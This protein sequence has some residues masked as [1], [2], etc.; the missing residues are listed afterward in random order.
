MRIFPGVA[1]LFLSVTLAAQ[2]FPE[3]PV[4]D[5]SYF[6]NSEQVLAAGSDG[7]G[8]LV[9]GRRDTSLFAHRVTAGGALLDGTGIKLATPPGTHGGAIVLGIFWAG[10]AYTVVCRT[11]DSDSSSVF[12]TR[13]D[14]DGRLLEDARQVPTGGSS[15]A[16]AT[17]GKRIVIAGPKLA[18]LDMH[19]N[20]I[21]SLVPLPLQGDSNLFQIASNG[22]GFLV[23]WQTRLELFRFAAEYTILD[24]NGHPGMRQTA[25]SSI[26]YQSIASDGHDYL[27]VY[28]MPQN[29]E[30][31]QHMSA[32]GQL[33]EQH[34]LPILYPVGGY[35]ILWS[36]SAYVVAAQ[37]GAVPEVIR[38]D[39][40]GAAIDTKAVSLTNQGVSSRVVLATNGRQV[41]MSWAETTDRVV[42]FAGLLDSDF[43]L[44][45][46]VPIGLTATVQTAP[47]IA[48][49]GT[50]LFAVWVEGTTIYGARLSLTGQRLGDPIKLTTSPINLP[51]RVIWD[52]QAYVVASWMGYN[53]L[54]TTRVAAD[55]TVLQ[56]AQ[57]KVFSD[58][59]GDFDLASDGSETVFVVAAKC[60]DTGG[61]IAARVHR[62]GNPEPKITIAPTGMLAGSPRAA[63]NG[64]ELLVVWR[65]MFGSQ[66]TLLAPPTYRSNVR[67]ARVSPSMTLLDPDP[68]RIAV[69]DDQDN[70][71]PQVA[72]DGR[73]FLVAWT[74]TGVDVRARTVRADGTLGDVIPALGKGTASS[75]VWDG[76]RYAV[77]FSS[78]A[79][80]TFVRRIGDALQIVNDGPDLTYDASLATPGGGA[81]IAAYDRVASEPVYG[82]VPRVFV[83]GVSGAVR[84]RPVRG[85]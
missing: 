25:A 38:L 28:Q 70:T 11:D 52:G 13:I 23:T 48:S 58:C 51:P 82:T 4:S 43:T 19:G 2:T 20:L 35:T 47:S 3:R 80:N 5:V 22:D 24:A 81:L 64:T 36:G 10:D 26:Y 60:F 57:K 68:L 27:L 65:E 74:R 29:G 46:R 9:V 18:I 83:K 12:V 72:S 85:R 50:N 14:L 1:L 40:T 71:M 53:L 45:Q 30:I 79:G 49:N 44:V 7:D 63:W 66:N 41:L 42:S 37:A 56:A 69:S 76:Q 54:T 34:P 15:F 73:D 84:V 39:R 21:E 78:Y 61:L 8:F 75:M 6:H 32:A 67:A 33:L 16:A 77:A 17:N 59:I 62:D 55:G 31:A